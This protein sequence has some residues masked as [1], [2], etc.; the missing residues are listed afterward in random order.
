MD[1]SLREGDW[2]RVDDLTGRVAEVRWRFTT[3]ETANGERVVVPNAWLLKNRFVVM[4]PSGAAAVRRWVRIPVD[5][6]PSPGDVA[7]VLGECISAAA[8]PHLSH[9]RKPDVVLLE[10]AGR[11]ATYAIR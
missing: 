3:F 10:V 1:S 6:A 7:G 2:V 5:L 11:S 9:A 8:I 4:G